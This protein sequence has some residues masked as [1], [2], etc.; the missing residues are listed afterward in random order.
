MLFRSIES[1]LSGPGLDRLPPHL[2]EEAEKLLE[3]RRAQQM[4]L[5]AETRKL[6]VPFHQWQEQTPMPG[7]ML[8]QGP[9][10]TGGGGGYAQV[11]LAVETRTMGRLVLDFT[12]IREHLTLKVEVQDTS[13]KQR[14]ERV[15]P[16]LR[17]RLVQRSSYAVATIL[18]QET[19]GARSISLLLPRRRDPRRLGRAIGV[20]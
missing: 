19:G 12:A 1:L 7:E 13:V 11:T 8:I 4:L 9:V 10:P 20:I 14:L 16:D 18:C 17:H 5:P 6:Y 15:L 2:Q 3:V